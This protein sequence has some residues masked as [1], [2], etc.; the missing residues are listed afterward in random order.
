[1]IPR[2]YLFLLGIWAV[3]VLPFLWFMSAFNGAPF[4]FFPDA[5]GPGSTVSTPQW[6][7]FVAIS[8]SPVWAAPF[9]HLGWMRKRS[10]KK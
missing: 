1:M 10:E 4:S 8:L 9:A 2:W 3:I 5:P 7:V 6:I